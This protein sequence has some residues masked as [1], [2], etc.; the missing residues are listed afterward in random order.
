MKLTWE[1]IEAHCDMV[2][3]VQRR[4]MKAYFQDGKNL[5]EIA[6]DE[7]EGEGE[8]KRAKT[9]LNL[10]IGRGCMAVLKSMLHRRDLSEPMPAAE[11]QNPEGEALAETPLPPPE[12]A[13]PAATPAE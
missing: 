11:T 1:D 7:L 3:D 6:A 12:A 2:S 13:S 10:S 9:S 5:M 8:L 4:R